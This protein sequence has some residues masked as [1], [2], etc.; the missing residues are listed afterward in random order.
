MQTQ[1]LRSGSRRCCSP[2]PWHLSVLVLSL[3]YC[4]LESSDLLLF[5]VLMQ[6]GSVVPVNMSA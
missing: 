1:E 3:V 5:L 2:R 6:G 4:V